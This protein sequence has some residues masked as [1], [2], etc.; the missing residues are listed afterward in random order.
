[1]ETY[2]PERCTLSAVRKYILCSHGDRVAL[3]PLNV[4]IFSNFCYFILYPFSLVV[5]RL[6]PWDN[7]LSL[8]L[9]HV[10]RLLNEFYLLI[11]TLVWLPYLNSKAFIRSHCH[12]FSLYLV[13]FFPYLFH[14]IVCTR[15]S[16]W[17]H[18]FDHMY[19]ISGHSLYFPSIKYLSLLHSWIKL[20]ITFF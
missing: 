11:F 10:S 8:V 7:A 13:R 2:S 6:F 14:Y 1:M 17:L 3:A 19:C 18:I 4:I 16:V 9:D 20:V 15:V 12:I 5:H